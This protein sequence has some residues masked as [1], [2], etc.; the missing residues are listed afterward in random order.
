MQ[1]YKI[2][3]EVRKHLL[4]WAKNFAALMGIPEG[5]TREQL[6]RQRADLVQA[7]YFW[8][9]HTCSAVFKE[10]MAQFQ[11]AW[12]SCK[13]LSQEEA[14]HCMEQVFKRLG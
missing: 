7:M 10:C 4:K 12:K 11:I 13:G 2:P 14:E 1:Q 3:E 8:P 9:D 5:P 6:H